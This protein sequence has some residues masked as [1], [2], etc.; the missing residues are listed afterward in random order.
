M[1]ISLRHRQRTSYRSYALNVVKLYFAQLLK[2]LEFLE[3]GLAAAL[4]IYGR[5]YSCLSMIV[6]KEGG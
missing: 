6:S 3:A 1:F 4:L 2:Y 5:E